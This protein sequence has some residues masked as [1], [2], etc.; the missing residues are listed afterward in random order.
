MHVSNHFKACMWSIVGALLMTTMT[1][2][3]SS[4]PVRSHFQQPDKP[5]PVDDTQLFMQA[6][7]SNC[8]SVLRGLV[9]EDFKLIATGAQQM[10]KISEAAHWPSAAD[11][12]YLHL[13]KEFQRQCDKLK[14]QAE[15]EDLQAAHYTY[16]HLST[17][18][19]DCH[20]YVRGRFRVERKPQGP[21]R[22][23]PTEWL[24]QDLP[25]RLPKRIPKDQPTN[26]KDA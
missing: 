3:L 23:I 11:D 20:N 18:C 12:V 15:A 24:P 1:W 25:E 8:Q 7:L 5:K 21:V 19:I 9:T 17:T 26:D 16:L 14:S 22:L 2:Q 6:K 13:G 4:I 10:K